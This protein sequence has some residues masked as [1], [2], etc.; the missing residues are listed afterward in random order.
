MIELLDGWSDELEN[1]FATWSTAQRRVER[2][3]PVWSQ[4]YDF[5]EPVN[6]PFQSQAVFHDSP[7]RF[8]GFSGPVG[9][10]KS[11]AL[12][13]EAL[14]L[15][16][17]NPGLPGL[18]GAPTYPMLRDVTRAAFLEG[19]QA[20]GVPYTFRAADNE[21]LLTEPRS[22]VRFRSLDNPE[23]LIGSN[24]AWFGVDELTYTKED[25]WHRLEARLRHPKASKLVGFGA[26]TPKG[27]DWV[28][29][30]FVGPERVKG[31]DAVLASPG[32]NKALPEDYYDRLKSSYDERF[33]EQEVL[34]RY[35]SIFAGQTY[36]AFLRDENV[37][38]LTFDPRF[39]LI[40]TMDFNV[41]P[42]ASAICQIVGNRAHVLQEIIL[43]NSN[44][45]ASCEVFWHRAQPYLKAMGGLPLRVHVYGDPAGNQMRTSASKSDWAIVRDAFAQWPM[46]PMSY[47][48][49]S[50][51]PAVKDRVN[52]MNGM[53]RNAYGERRLFV[54]PSCKELTADLEQVV[55]KTDAAG[56]SIAEID[57]S[58]LK[59]THVSDALGYMV[60][61]EFGIRQRGGPQS[62]WIA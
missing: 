32:E 49:A 37:M 43:P 6:A 58:N 36:H 17:A 61:K 26:W 5:R 4:F 60:E 44:T 59:R 38:P 31:Y 53:L 7:A 8:K 39:P 2:T 9:S 55:W 19:L 50:S 12:V 23:R 28:Y 47:M 62:G 29:E 41:N 3:G 14:A 16:Y 45:V 51:H 25:A 57:K 52:A 10:G 48:V 11:T 20:A 40:W 42:M 35:L 33:Y 13:A 22:V 15:A 54:D 30:K 24:L 34:G 21:V 56:S 18:I 46:L 1:E 27:F